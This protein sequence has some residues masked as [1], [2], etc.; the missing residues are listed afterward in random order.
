[1][2]GY[3]TVKHAGLMLEKASGAGSIYFA[4]ENVTEF[5]GHQ[6]QKGVEL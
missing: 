4:H 6:K 2:R 1:M 5:G 3:L